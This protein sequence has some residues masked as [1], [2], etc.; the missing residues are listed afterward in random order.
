MSKKQLR[1]RGNNDIKARVGELF[2]KE[3]SIV[4]KDGAVVLGTLNHVDGDNL[5]LLNGRRRRVVISVYDVEEVYIDL[6]P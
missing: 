5:V 1:I 2:G 4:K 3:T 6:E